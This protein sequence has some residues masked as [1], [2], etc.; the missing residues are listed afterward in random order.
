MIGIYGPLI[1]MKEFCHIS[2]IKWSRPQNKHFEP[3]Q[4]SQTKIRYA[5]IKLKLISFEW[6]NT[7]SLST[8]KL[9]YKTEKCYTFSSKALSCFLHSNTRLN[10]MANTCY[11]VA[12]YTMN[13]F[14]NILAGV[15]TNKVVQIYPNPPLL[16]LLSWLLSIDGLAIY[17]SVIKNQSNRI[18]KDLAWPC[19]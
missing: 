17:K 13:S 10:L 9:K 7:N 8:N 1:V 2:F 5:L 14:F 4:K 18:L 12:T 16:R 19:E 6:Y 3:N 11:S 15:F